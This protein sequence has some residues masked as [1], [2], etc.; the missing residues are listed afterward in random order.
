MF[1]AYEKPRTL[2]LASSGGIPHAASASND[3]RTP[4]SRLMHEK[5][6]IVQ[7]NVRLLK[8]PG[9]CSCNIPNMSHTRM[10]VVRR[11]E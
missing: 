8:C 9:V 2:R 7:D 6:N 10:S 5:I 1:L 4:Y 3:A 11:E